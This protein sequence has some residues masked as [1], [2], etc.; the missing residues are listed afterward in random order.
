M[1]KSIGQLALATG[2]RIPSRRDV[3]VLDG[4]G[5]PPG[6]KPW[7]SVWSPV[8]VPCEH[9]PNKCEATSRVTFSTHIPCLLQEANALHGPFCLARNYGIGLIPDLR[10]GTGNGTGTGTGTGT[11]IL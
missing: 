10:T 2:M 6:I 7:D 5:G 11:R 9:S 8:H 4:Q 1:S 3:F